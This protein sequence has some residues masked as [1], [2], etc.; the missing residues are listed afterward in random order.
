[1]YD[2]AVE[3]YIEDA[4]VNRVKV[5]FEVIFNGLASMAKNMGPKRDV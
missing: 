4:Y 1:M 3:G 5:N 2:E